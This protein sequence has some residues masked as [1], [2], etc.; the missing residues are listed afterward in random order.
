MQG[1]SEISYKDNYKNAPYFIEGTN[2]AFVL[3]DVMFVPR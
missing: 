2:K 1:L 3:C